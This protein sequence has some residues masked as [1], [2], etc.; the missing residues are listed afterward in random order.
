MGFGFLKLVLRWPVKQSIIVSLAKSYKLETSTLPIDDGNIRIN[1]ELFQ[2]IFGILPGEQEIKK[3]QCKNNKSCEGCMFA[4][5]CQEPELWLFAMTATELSALAS[6]IQLQDCVNT[7]GNDVGVVE[8][9]VSK[10]MTN[11]GPEREGSRCTKRPLGFTK[12]TIKLYRKEIMLDIILDHN[13]SAIEQALNA[14]DNHPQPSMNRNK[15]R[16]KR[17]EVKTP[18]TAPGTK[19]MLRRAEGLPKK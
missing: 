19:S 8:G 1:V 12:D 7:S 11:P 6:T 18:F 3:Y 15:P 10:V 13:N 9:H 17:K 5:L 2:R 14:F 4:L 16:N